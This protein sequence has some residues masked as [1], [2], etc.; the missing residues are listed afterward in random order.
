MCNNMAKDA[1]TH[2]H[3]HGHLILGR[4]MFL[5]LLMKSDVDEDK[6]ESAIK[7]S[8]L[9]HSAI[10]LHDHSGCNHATEQHHRPGKTCKGQ[11]LREKERKNGLI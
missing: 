9:H 4:I 11:R 3:E 10:K 5:A 8:Q 6:D 2:E 7:L 1:Q